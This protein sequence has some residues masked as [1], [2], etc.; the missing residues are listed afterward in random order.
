M[1]QCS[2]LLEPEEFRAFYEKALP[3]VYGYFYKRC[4][5]RDEMAAELTQDTFLSAVVT[6]RRG[7]VVEAP[8]PWIVGI[9]RRRL[10]D[11]YRKRARVR[12]DEAFGNASGFLETS[13]AEV[14]LTTALE[15]LP[16]NYRLAL[17]LR[18]VDDLPV[19]DVAAG[20]NKSLRATESLLAR[21]RAALVDAYN[22]EKDNG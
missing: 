7:A 16:A 15:S 8:L 20:I 5:G 11:H 13:V 4:S 21:A 18:Y 9:A 14:R 10:I 1:D 12:N 2:D 19:R 3:V 22:E 6:L 17:I